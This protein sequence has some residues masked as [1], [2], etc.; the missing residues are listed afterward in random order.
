MAEGSLPA[1]FAALPVDQRQIVR[2][3]QARSR[4]S[5]ETLAKTLKGFKSVAEFAQPLLEAAL[6][7]KFG[8]QVDTTKTWWYSEILTDALGTD[9]TLLQLALRNFREG[10]TF[11]AR[12]LIAEQGEPAPMGRGSEGLYGWYYPKSGP[13]KC[14]KIKKLPIPPAEF[15]ALCRELDIGKQYQDHLQA[16]FDAE[17]KRTAVKAQTITA[18]KDNLRVHAHLAHAQARISPS[19]YLA[20][21]GVL[22]GEK[23]HSW[24][25][26]RSRSVSCMYSAQP[27]AK[28]SSSAPAD[29]KA[30]KSISAG[31]TPV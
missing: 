9:Q 21:L 1:W 5:N 19:G 26:K 22:N 15:A 6:E 14:Y 30:R 29:A 16:I 18:W 23:T 7:K 17:D 4:T 13:S 10:Q 20:L 24:T 2:D 31:I 3:S 28:C 25:V 8:L 12:E 11:S 27:S